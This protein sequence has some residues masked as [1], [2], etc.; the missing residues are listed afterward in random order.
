[1]TQSL[2]RGAAHAVDDT[3]ADLAT[4]IGADF[5][6]LSITPQSAD[7]APGAVRDQLAR[8]APYDAGRGIDLRPYA[9][10]DLGDAS[11][12][13]RS[14]G[15]AFE[16]IRSH[17][18]VAWDREVFVL[19]VGGDHS[20]TWPLV[21]AAASRA[22]R[23]GLVQLDAHHDVRPLTGGPSN[24]TPVRGIVEEGLAA[25]PDIVQIGIHPFANHPDLGAYCT[26]Q[27]ITTIGLDE[28]R[29]EGSAAI[30]QRALDR[31][32]DCDLVYLTVDIDVLDRGHAPGTVGALPGGIDPASLLE[33]VSVLCEAP[34]VQAM[35][36]VEFDP[37]RDCSDITARAVA[38]VMMTGL[39]SVAARMMEAR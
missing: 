25:G 11:A 23:I 32:Q 16:A 19:A 35:D 17:A 18:L 4:L 33:L 5:S 3:R 14:W 24:G 7:E 29:A 22:G 15:D 1:V 12:R 28:W 13:R 20:V 36:V 30:A 10:T 6:A 34:V 2:F 38:G 26:A 21:S 8:F 31:L 27:G 37:A 9:V 39:A